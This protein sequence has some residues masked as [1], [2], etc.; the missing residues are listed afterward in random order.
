[1][2][3]A[4]AS[5]ARA[6]PAFLPE[7]GGASGRPGAS[8][9]GLSAAGY[10]GRRRGFRGP[11]AP[12]SRKSVSGHKPGGPCRKDTGADPGRRPGAQDASGRSPGR[13]KNETVTFAAMS[14]ATRRDLMRATEAKLIRLLIRQDV[15]YVIPLYQRTYSWDKKQRERLWDDIMS[16]GGDDDILAHFVG[17][18][19][20][21]KEHTR[22]N[23]QLNELLVIDGQQRLTTIVLI[24]AA[25]AGK[26]GSK[27][28]EGFTADKIRSLYLTNQFQEGENRHKLLLSSTDRESLKAIVDEKEDSTSLSLH[29]GQNFDWFIKQIEGLD[30]GGIGNL[31]R[32]LNKLTAI[33]MKLDRERDKPQRIFE[34]M[35][36]TGRGLSQ[37]DLIRNFV[38]M[39]LEKDEQ[40]RLY[41]NHWRRM[42]NDFG[43]EEFEEHFD[44][45]MR[46]YLTLRTKAIPKV[47]EVYEAF[48]EHTKDIDRFEQVA[49]IHK[50][51][52]YYRAM[53]LGKEQNA[54]LAKAFY[55]LRMLK[56]EVAYPLLLDLYHD[57]K[58]GSLDGT[59]LAGIVRA[60]ESYIFR[61]AICGLPSNSHNKIMLEILK[62]YSGGDK[63]SHVIKYLLDGFGRSRR[64]PNDEEFEDHF[65]RHGYSNDAY[66]LYRLENYG[67]KEITVEE[68]TERKYTIEHIMP[69]TLNPAWKNSLGP[70][71]K[72]IHDAYL[73]SPGN[74]TLTA[75]NQKL[76]N[77]AFVEK[78]DMPG[79]FRQSR[80]KINK[81]LGSVEKWDEKAI[82]KRA[83][84]LAEMAVG[85]WARP[86]TQRIVRGPSSGAPIK[87]HAK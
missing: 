18:I 66:W 38:L 75:H 63:R 30:D 53:A 57:Y 83:G 37:A 3:A 23:P 43:Q 39:D 87:S 82:E 19:V 55:D 31:C 20:H 51:A 5:A 41:M 13:A 27:K 8:M 22:Q 69:Q 85:V 86:R 58:R 67:R 59:D 24:L 1:M 10:S 60:I 36:A 32:G 47:D 84:Q 64:W 50:F 77:R 45:F 74:I 49:D 44:K 29:I 9:G 21:V 14:L 7:S 2:P 17:S 62:E 11:S 26:I 40:N 34:S 28:I 56:A 71:H 46:H 70:R 81:S 35:N 52:E 25:L 76:S 79:G 72:D 48:K 61:R 65:A 15:Q 12:A 33:E 54:E 16:A 78:R 73:D 68:Y 42:E 4:D 80:L 6:Q